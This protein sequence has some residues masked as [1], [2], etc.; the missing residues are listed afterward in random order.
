V[1][2][3]LV[4]R[5]SLGLTAVILAGSTGI[6]LIISGEVNP[7]MVTVLGMVFAYL[8]GRRA[9]GAVVRHINGRNTG[10]G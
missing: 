5:V 6:H 1:N 7:H 3:A 9:N 4:E 2:E 8:V 10:G